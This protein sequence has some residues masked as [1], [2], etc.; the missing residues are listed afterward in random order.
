MLSERTKKILKEAVEQSR[1]VWGDIDHLVNAGPAKMLDEEFLK[2]AD[3]PTS[4]D[5]EN[6]FSDDIRANR[7]E[8]EQYLAGLLGMM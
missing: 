1:Q 4:D 3:V 8:A 6:T 7:K 2:E 5:P